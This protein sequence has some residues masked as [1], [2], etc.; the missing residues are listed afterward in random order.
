ML[1]DLSFLDHKRAG[2]SRSSE[3]FDALAQLPARNRPVTWLRLRWRW[4]EQSAAEHR[5]AR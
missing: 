1:S 4:S 5:I 3:A 2:S